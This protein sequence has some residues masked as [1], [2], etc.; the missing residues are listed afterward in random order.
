MDLAKLGLALQAGGLGFQGG[1]P[2]AVIEPFL[3]KQRDAAASE[4]IAGMLSGLGIQGPQAELISSLPLGMQQ[5]YLTNRMS[6]QDQDRRRR[7]AAA[8]VA[9]VRKAE[10]EARFAA[11]QSYLRPMPDANG[12]TIAAAAAPSQLTK[13]ALIRAYTDPRLK[14]EDRQMLAKAYDLQQP[15]ERRIVTGKDGHKYY[16][17]TGERVLPNAQAPKPAPSSKEQQIERLGEVGINRDLAILIADGVLQT[18]RDPVSGV[19]QIVDT[20]TGQPWQGMPSQAQATPPVPSEPVPSETGALPTLPVPTVPEANYTG[21]F[22]AEGAASNVLNAGADALGINLPYPERQEASTALN[23][24]ALRTKTFMQQAFPGRASVQLMQEL[25]KITAQPNRI[26]MGEQ[27]GRDMLEQTAGMID[28]LIRQEERKLK[29]PRA[30]TP[31]MRA[32]A[33]SNIDALEQLS[34]DYR[35]VLQSMDGDAS[36]NR[37]SSGVTWRVVE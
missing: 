15:K 6:Q 30:Y 11:V 21:A 9:A 20:R 24:L 23:N 13:D 28:S 33:R 18:S 14:A 16:A 8:Q 5:Q 29:A 17:D 25:D 10:Q 7:A 37:T 3:Q 12:P 22:G 19:T 34:A 32:E 1:N 2:Q 27:R 36:E 31:Q 35:A 4:K 26:L